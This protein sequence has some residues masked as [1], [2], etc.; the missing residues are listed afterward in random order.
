[1]SIVLV[2]ADLAELVLDDGEL[3][4]MVAREQVVQQ[5]GLAR[6]QEA[7]EHGHRNLARV[8]LGGGLGVLGLLVWHLAVLFLL[9]SEDKIRNQN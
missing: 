3:H 9:L 8:G 7:G 5:R 4:T 6:A 1:M 2:D